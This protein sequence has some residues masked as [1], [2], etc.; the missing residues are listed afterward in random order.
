MAGRVPET[1]QM[2]LLDP[3]PVVSK[4]SFESAGNGDFINPSPETIY[5][6]NQRLRDYLAQ[7]D[8]EWVLRLRQ[9][10]EE[11]NLSAFNAG[12]QATGRK[13]IHPLIMLGLIVYG[14]L[15]GKWSLRE[16]ES[17]AVRD[18]G[19]WWL[20]GGVQPDHSTVG[21]F[22]NRFRDI[23]TEEYFISLTGML[24][25]KL[26]I[27]G[28][29]AAG[30]GTVIE[31]A[32]SRYKVIK[33][34]A[35]RQAA[36]EARERAENHSGDEAVQKAAVKARMVAEAAS[37]REA[38]VRRNRRDPKNLKI[39]T[40]EPEAVFQ[41]LKNGATRPAY[42][43]S[44]LANA[45]RMIVGKYIDPSDEIVAVRPMLEQYRRIFGALPER[46]MFDAGYH[47]HK[48]LVLSMEL[49]LDVLCPSGRADQGKWEKQNHAG[50]FSKREFHYDEER[51]VYICPAGQELIPRAREYRDGQDCVR[52]LCRSCKACEL[53]SRCTS[54]K[55]GRTIRRFEGDK[56][57]EAMIEVFENERAKRAYAQRKA[58]VEPVISE[59]RGLQKL[60]K[61]H[62]R[63]LEGVGVE[64]SLHCTAY[65]LKRAIR[66]EV[67]GLFRFVFV[68]NRG[69]IRL[70]GLVGWLL[71]S[72]Q[73]CS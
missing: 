5:I 69:K 51:D 37:E 45:E 46:A 14:I 42:K 9:L 35:A 52:Y 55:R 29:D 61:F 32:A 33:A 4:T 23:L 20:C 6:G 15:D 38:R 34:E 18:L 28:G 66:L 48:V 62:R 70:W 71:T 39:S 24:I 22:I 40:T 72:S 26:H 58:M 19:A 63:G 68:Q 57:K 10:L 36:L 64:F 44:V 73:E 67:R 16:L 17:L 3:G 11:S 1:A 13:A 21:N 47:K 54:A 12:Y 27:T 8:M 59:I 49:N 41:P 43:P 50:K 56:L 31:A 30:D 25:K 60:N 65:N 2:R 53:R 7:R